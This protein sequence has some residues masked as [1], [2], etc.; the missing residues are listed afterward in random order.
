MTV[1]LR[2]SKYCR[3]NWFFFPFLIKS[4]LYMQG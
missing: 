1:P 2:D 4:T 3:S